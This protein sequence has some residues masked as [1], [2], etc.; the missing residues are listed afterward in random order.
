MHLPLP[1]RAAAAALALFVLPAACTASTSAWHPEASTEAGSTH[2]ALG[3][4]AHV[5]ASFELVGQT[6]CHTDDCTGRQDCDTPREP[7][8]SQVT[9]LSCAPDCTAAIAPSGTE[10]A[11]GSFAI[12][13]TSADEGSKTVSFVLVGEGGQTAR[14]TAQLVFERPTRIELLRDG[15]ANAPYG[16]TYASFV[17]ASQTWCTELD[18]A[19]GPLAYDSDLLS[20]AASAGGATSIESKQDATHPRRCD[21]IHSESPGTFHVTYTYGD[22]TRRETLRVLA[23]DEVA[24]A[25]LVSFDPTIV[26][27]DTADQATLAVDADPFAAGTAVKAVTLACGYGDG[28]AYAVRVVATDGTRGL[29]RASSL[30]ARPTYIAH[31]EPHGDAAFSLS[32]AAY[33]VDGDGTL[34]ATFGDVRLDVPVHAPFCGSA[35]DDAGAAPDAARDG[36]SDAAPDAGDAAVD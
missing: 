1:L 7:L 15:V 27:T 10:P 14:Q 23:A 30:V 6:T 9:E 35:D 24:R 25:E 4:H 36:A 22:L 16:T 34:S 3:S 12:D 19:S 28:R 29:A 11:K 8:P 20:V 21:R 17:D 33:P 18:G 2:V 32:N 5:T 26:A 13:V 31:V